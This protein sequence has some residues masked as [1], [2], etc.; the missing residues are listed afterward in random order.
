MPPDD[1]LG[2]NG[3]CLENFLRLKTS[4]DTAPP[5]PYGK[6]C[7]YGNK[8]KFYHAERGNAPHKSVTERLKEQSTKQIMEVRTRTHSRDSSPGEQLSRAKSMNLPM[9]LHRTESDITVFSRA[10]QPLSR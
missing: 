3:P 1:P 7:T 9:Q 8:C 2:R 10:K 6:K 4:G 5:C